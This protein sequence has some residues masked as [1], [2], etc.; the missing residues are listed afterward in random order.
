[1]V[2]PA[3]QK[4]PRPLLTAT[5]EEL[6]QR[7]HQIA[8][9]IQSFTMKADMSPSV[10]GIHGGQVTDYPTISGLIVFLKPDNIRV[11]GLD[12][13]IHSTAFDMV[14]T[15]ND[16]RVSIPIKNQ[17]F[18]GQND[19]PATSKNKLENLRPSAFLTAL[20][21]NPPDPT[22]TFVEDD[23]SETK[24]VYILMMIGHEGDRYFPVRNVYFDRYTLQINRQKT[25]DHAGEIVSETRYSNWADHNGIWFPSTIDIQRPKD[26]YEV[27]L[28]VTDLKINA[29]GITPAKFI[30]N[31]PPGSQLRKLQ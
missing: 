25:F 18:E 8:D 11:I 22:S 15:G 9:P 17:F 13:V 30:L 2:A 10:G 19:A 5:R 14:S 6:L 28:Q 21:I 1:M 23:T 26:G 3:G 7:V 31:Q 16:F 29:G 20:L 27:V 4:V 24:A 12:P